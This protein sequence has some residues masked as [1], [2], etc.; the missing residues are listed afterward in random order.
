M[1][2]NLSEWLNLTVRWFHI[3]AGILWVGQ[4]YYFTWLDGRFAEA[5]KGAKGNSVGQVWMVHSG[6][7]YVVEKQKGLER[8]PEKL[9]WFRWEAALTWIS[10]MILLVLVYYMGGALVDDSI[11]DI[12]VGT[13]VGIGLGLLVVAWGVY[14]LLCQSP[15][16]RSESALAASSY[17]LIVLAAYGLTHVLS[18]RAAYI[19]VGAMFGT[20]MTLNVWMRILPA[21]RRMIAAVQEG[22]KPDERLAARAKLRSKHN[23]YMAVPVVFLMISNHFPVATYGS[24]H[25]WVTLS[26][27]V[28]AGWGAAK[29]IRRA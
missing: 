9:H 28:L 1:D 24:R 18:G 20:L 25:N 3:F 7:F 2:F 23:M 5:E 16:G 13:G 15:L 17:V 8:L 4:T 21:Q 10:G 22:R 6:G 26:A 12:G 29:L 11:A 19:H 14:D 27:L